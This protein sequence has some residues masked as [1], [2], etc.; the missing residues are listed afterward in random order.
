[1]QL[2]LKTKTSSPLAIHFFGLKGPFSDMK[3][4]TQIYKH[5]FTDQVSAPELWEQDLRFIYVKA[6]FVY[7]WKTFDLHQI[8]VWSPNIFFKSNNRNWLTIFYKY[9]T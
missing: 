1:M 4:N 8:F 5:D 2:I 7:H 6:P 9:I 3:I